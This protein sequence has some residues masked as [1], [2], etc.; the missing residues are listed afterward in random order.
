MVLSLERSTDFRQVCCWG[1]GERIRAEGYQ[2]CKDIAG[3]IYGS[4]VQQAG[5]GSIGY[6]VLPDSDTR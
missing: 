5:L 6:F 4:T 3:F 1:K 2:M